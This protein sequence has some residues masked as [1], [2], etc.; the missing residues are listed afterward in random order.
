VWT[1]LVLVVLVVSSL[2]ESVTLV[3]WGWVLLV[4][5]AVKAAQ[6]RSWRHGLPEEHRPG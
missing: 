4:I 6:G 1:A 2:A 5:C 3:E